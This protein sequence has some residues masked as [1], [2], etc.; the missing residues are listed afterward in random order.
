MATLLAAI[1]VNDILPVFVVAGVGFLLARYVKA[2]VKTL[3]RTTFNAFAPCL[4]FHLLVTSSLGANDFGRM[5]VYAVSVIALVG[6]VGRLAAIPLRLD[7]Q[8][9]AAFLI[10]VMFSNSGN[11]GL[12]A[13]L[14]AFGREALTHASIY[15][16]TNAVLMYTVGVFL[17]SAGRAPVRQALAGVLRVPAVYGVLLAAIVMATGITLPP[18]VMRP[19]SLLA[20]ASIPVMLVVLGMQLERGRWPARPAAVLT[21]VLLVLV[22]CPLIGTALASLVGLAGVARQAAIAQ[23][24]MPAAVVNTIIALEY[25]VEPSFVTAVV[26]VSTLASPLTVTLVFALLGA[27]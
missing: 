18:A 27:R 12:S 5:I 11:F 15:F 17:A 3:S 4:V 19:V 24:A 2:D 16:V 23:A 9:L 21:A 8:A 13:I 7:R 1:L 6:L 26:F 14:F 25:D 22:A 20:D 10:V